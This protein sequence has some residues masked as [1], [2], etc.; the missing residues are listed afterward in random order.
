M[1]AR[2]GTKV[3]IGRGQRQVGEDRVAEVGIVMLAGVDQPRHELAAC[4]ERVPQRR[5]LHEIGPC[6]GDQVDGLHW[7]SILQKNQ[8]EPKPVSIVLIVRKTISK[9]SQGEKYLM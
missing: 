2:A 1:A 9:S 6:G 7:G 3:I 8:R 5:D 4:L